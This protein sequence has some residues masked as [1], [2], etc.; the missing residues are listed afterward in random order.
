MAK[1]THHYQTLTFLFDLSNHSPPALPNGMRTQSGGARAGCLHE[2]YA[3]CGRVGSF[4]SPAK[5]TL[6]HTHTYKYTRTPSPYLPCSF[7]VAPFRSTIGFN[8]A[9]SERKQ[10][11]VYQD[12][13]GQLPCV[14]VHDQ[15]ARKRCKRG[16]VFMPVCVCMCVREW[17][18]R[19]PSVSMPTAG[20]IGRFCPRIRNQSHHQCGI[21][22]TRT[23][24]AL[25]KDTR[26]GAEG[27]VRQIGQR[28]KTAQ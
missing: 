24:A 14:I 6:T 4:I 19:N 2:R 13:V 8:S 26:T 12:V 10:I 25:H 7:H 27:L 20:P 16:S 18:I 22:H 23:Q 5:L 28:G 21:I 15:T 9:P 3:F 17:E 1:Q 11:N